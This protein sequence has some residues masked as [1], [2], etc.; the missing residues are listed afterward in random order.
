MARQLLQL[1][2]QSIADIGFQAGF[3]SSQ[4]FTRVFKKHM[5]MPPGQYREQ[6][7]K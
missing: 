2:T 4:N 1:T 7:G 5:G 6:H 3:N